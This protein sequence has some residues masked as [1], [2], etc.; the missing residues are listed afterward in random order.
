M[1]SL[2][3]NL[4]N[5]A[6]SENSKNQRYEINKSDENNTEGDE[7]FNSQNPPSD[8][9]QRDVEISSGYDKNPNMNNPNDNNNQRF[10]F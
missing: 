1:N 9:I 10:G 5:N 6:T 2:E 7:N 3:K 4:K 8:K